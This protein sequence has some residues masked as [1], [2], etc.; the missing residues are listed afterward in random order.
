MTTKSTP[1]EVWTSR[2]AA[3]LQNTITALGLPPILT[4]GYTLQRFLLRQ[5]TDPLA[6]STIPGSVVWYDCADSAQ[7]KRWYATKFKERGKKLFLFG[8]ACVSLKNH[9]GFFNTK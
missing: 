4:P 1:K 2:A 8:V 6:K 3:R 7:T 9:S 5:L